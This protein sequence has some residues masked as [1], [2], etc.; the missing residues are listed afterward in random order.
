MKV[1]SGEIYIT[2]TIDIALVLFQD[3][4]CIN[5]VM[6]PGDEEN[7]INEFYNVDFIVKAYDTTGWIKYGTLPAKNVLEILDNY[8][9]VLSGSEIKKN[10]KLH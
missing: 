9:K 1:R 5:C 10:V 4:E 7:L 3:E 8:Q 2:P 6:A